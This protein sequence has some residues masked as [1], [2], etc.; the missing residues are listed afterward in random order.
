[1]I[2]NVSVVGYTEVIV[3][4]VVTIFLPSVVSEIY[5]QQCFKVFVNMCLHKV[6]CVTGAER[7]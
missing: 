3:G 7:S 4:Q 1:M 2:Y 6:V 5:A